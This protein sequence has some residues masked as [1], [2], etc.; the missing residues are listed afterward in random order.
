MHYS[1]SKS[2]ILVFI[3]MNMDCIYFVSAM[4]NRE[5]DGDW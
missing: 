5:V 4:S 1:F 3:T 2:T